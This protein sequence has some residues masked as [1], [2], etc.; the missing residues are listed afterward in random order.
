MSNSK[1][2]Q[3]VTLIGPP[4]AGKGTQA[5]LLAEKFHLSYLETS[6]VLEETFW[7]AS[8]DA[9]FEVEGKKYYH[10]DQKVLWQTGKLCDP[11]FVTQL[12]NEKFETAFREGK[13][14]LLAGSPRT[15]WE[16]EREMPLLTKLYGKENL[17]IIALEISPEQSLERNSK[18]RICELMRHPI[19]FT[20]ENKGL[21]LCPL[22]GSRLMK[23]EGLDD[24]ETMGTRLKEYQNRTFPL[25]EYFKTLELQVHTINGDQSVAQV[26]EDIQKALALQ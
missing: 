4:G 18:R 12:M 20:E 8:E 16:G 19:L 3:V 11:P 22:D 21:T 14:L 13:S 24:P 23:R 5:G 17:K 6:K 15:V 1:A 7:D 9:F 10:K 2:L 25:F 26:F